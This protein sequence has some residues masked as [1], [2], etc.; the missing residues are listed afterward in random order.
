MTTTREEEMS[1]KR[2]GRKDQKEERG[3]EAEGGEER[4]RE[5]E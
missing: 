1:R 2:S 3:K 5:R 4:E